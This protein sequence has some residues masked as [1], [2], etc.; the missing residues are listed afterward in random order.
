VA[1]NTGTD[2][3]AALIAATASRRSAVRG[4]AAA[5]NRAPRPI[6]MFHGESEANGHRAASLGPTSDGATVWSLRLPVPYRSA[7]AMMPTAIVSRISC[8]ERARWR[9]SASVQRC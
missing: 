7:I 2:Q 5:T 6:G 3:V 8:G 9:G 4:S 1:W